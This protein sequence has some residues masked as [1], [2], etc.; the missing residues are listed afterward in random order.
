MAVAN[1]LAYYNTATVTTVKS[2]MAQAPGD[3]PIKLFMAVILR[4][5]F[6]ICQ[7]VSPW[8]AF[9]VWS[10]LIFASK[11]GAYQESINRDHR[12]HLKGALVR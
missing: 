12:V 10:V 11:A 7:C 5:F 2:F 6:V 3:N 9:P 4:I 1:T 8:Q